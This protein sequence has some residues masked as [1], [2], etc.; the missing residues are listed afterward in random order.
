MEP[1]QTSTR[2]S[3]AD[4]NSRGFTLVELLVVIAIIGVLVALLLPAVQA[5]RESARR[6]SCSN[7]LKNMALAVLTHHD[8]KKHFPLNYGAM[9]SDE[10]PSGVTQ[11]GVGWIVEILPQ[12]EQQPLFERFKQGG[13]YE[14]QFLQGRWTRPAPSHDLG[15]NSKKDGVSVPDLM[16][17]VLPILVCPS[18]AGS[19][20]IRDDQKQWN[21]LPVA[22]T[23]YKGVLGDTYLGE[24]LGD[25][26][27]Y[28][29]DASK[30]P[31]GVYTEESASG[32]ELSERDCHADARCHGIFFRQSFQR[33]IRLKEVTDGTSNTLMLGE[34]I[35]EFNPHS[36]A[37][38]A[39]GSWCS[40][41]IPPNNL[42][43]TDPAL[44]AIEF[45][46]EQQGF[47]S[48]HPAGLQFA[49]VDGSARFISDDIDLESYRTSCTRNGEEPV[50]AE[51]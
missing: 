28:H 46:W 40:C 4:R 10:A 17:T 21:G 31:S 3:Q 7:N 37:Y 41:N 8:I 44:H 47:R 1:S 18:D 29:N 30:Y 13:A 16:R 23:S 50:G 14:G 26:P 2:R 25:H 11:S 45:W 42:L 5:A 22:V 39:N 20:R 32:F 27:P 6:M 9:W 51:F 43:N 35:P 19:E 38:Y 36:A 12:L 33:P 34:D 15:L 48:H 24:T 49:L